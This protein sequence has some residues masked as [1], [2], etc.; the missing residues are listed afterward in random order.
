MQN[1]NS[2]KIQQKSKS[3]NE[4]KATEHSNKYELETV[5]IPPLHCWGCGGPH[6]VKNCPYSKGEKPVAQIEEASTMGEVERS[7]P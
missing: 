6:Y 3:Q 1:R 7:M 4:L 2:G 5:A